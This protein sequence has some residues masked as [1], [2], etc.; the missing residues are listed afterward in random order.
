MTPQTR[1]LNEFADKHGLDSRSIAEILNI[2][3]RQVRYWLSENSEKEIPYASAVALKC[4]IEHRPKS[5]DPASP[6]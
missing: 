2:T 3:S 1:A 6:A 4:L 5:A